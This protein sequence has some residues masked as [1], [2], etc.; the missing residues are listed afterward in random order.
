[1]DS[2][3]GWLL[4]RFLLQGGP[5]QVTII[6]IDDTLKGIDKASGGYFSITA[7]V[8]LCAEETGRGC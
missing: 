4:D 7:G 8:R 3:F 5:Q 1:M 2:I 6:I